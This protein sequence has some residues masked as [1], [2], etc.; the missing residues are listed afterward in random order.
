MMP[1]RRIM[2]QA[3]VLA[4]VWLVCGVGV[5]LAQGLPADLPPD[6]LLQLSQQLGHAGSG[7]ENV[8]Q[9]QNSPLALPQAGGQ[10]YPV[11]TGQGYGNGATFPVRQPLPPLPVSALESDY[12]H[13]AGTNLRQYGYDLFHGFQPSSGQLL[14]GAVPDDYRLGIGDTVVVSLRGQV[15]KSLSV[16]VD[17]DGQVILPDLAPIPAAGRRFGDWRQD[18]VQRVGAAYVN[19]QVFVSLGAVRQISVAVVG[20]VTSPGMVTLGGFGTVLDALA[21]AGGI[22]KTGTLR[23]I[24]VIHADGSSSNLDLYPVIGAA[25]GPVQP[26]GLEDGDRIEVGSIGTTAAVSGAVVRPGIYEL[27]SAHG[28][29]GGDLLA[30]GGGALR[31]EGSR[32]LKLALTEA[33]IDQAS[34]ARNPTRMMLRGSDILVVSPRADTVT[35]QV[36]LDG[37]VRLPGVRS[38]LT[39][40]TVA[41]LVGDLSSLGE[42]PYLPFAVLDTTDPQTLARHFVPV[43]LGRAIGGLDPT[44]LHDN[45]V[46]IVLGADDIRYLASPEVQAVLTGRPLNNAAATTETRATNLVAGPANTGSQNIL[47]PF[48]GGRD[49]GSTGYQTTASANLPYQTGSL[50]NESLPGNRLDTGAETTTGAS[51]E[52]TSGGQ[53]TATQSTQLCRG[54][55]SLAE[56][57]ATGDLH[58]FANAVEIAPATIPENLACPM[59]Y[60][61]YPTLL[62]FVLEYAASLSGAVREPGIYP[63]VDGLSLKAL[64]AT[65][66][67]LSHD[68]DLSAVEITHYATAA[69]SE[70]QSLNLTPDELDQVAL[71][72]GDAVRINATASDRESGPVT[73][74][75]AF[76]RPGI[77]DIRRGEHLSEVIARAG[78]LTA[79]AYPY[80]AV[81]TRLEVQKIQQEATERSIRE[82]ESGLFAAVQHTSSQSNSSAQS[83][84][85]LLAQ[86]VDDMR[87]TTTLGRIVIE[88]DPAV[89]DVKPQLDLVL[90]P[91]DSLTM[92]KRPTF[93][94]VSGEVLNPGS[95]EFIAG[96]D[97]RDYL[98]KAGGYTQN[99]DPDHVFVIYPNGAAQPVRQAFWNFTPLKIPPGSTIIVP[100][101]L[102]PYDAIGLTTAISQ[103]VGQLAITGASL[104][105][106]GR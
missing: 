88:A 103:I 91:G 59:I 71:Q 106:I 100:R 104:A 51:A 52:A 89:L 30:L 65:A 80:G 105:V 102:S 23:H 16:P 31:A 24:A 40:A 10:S 18:L 98:R 32:Y 99:A 50:G 77:Y 49:E 48:S 56:I 26:L 87:H 81:F 84:A 41:D 86:V 34:E 93:V 12:S 14:A 25:F 72:P 8:V 63:L 83:A 94:T 9:P 57:L 29:A 13:R 43:D 64:I 47:A 82:L 75:G 38:R 73:L 58:R 36:Y 17:R 39:A 46:L 21:L 68:A 2:W 22:N 42:A 20:E 5:V 3:L 97:V 1:A 11:G 27:A 15:S 70:R 95:E 67:G 19:T 69:G 79:D 44:P 96:L 45:D 7:S 78:G 76:A 90:E 101:D 62:P 6:V 60:D 92:P 54:L 35:G 66:D 85:P 37:H 55:Q 74:S 28:I 61:R 4:G 33:G 53:T